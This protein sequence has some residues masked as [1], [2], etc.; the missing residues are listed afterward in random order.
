MCDVITVGAATYDIFLRSKDF[1]IMAA[2][3]YLTGRAECVPLGAKIEVRDITF[4]I[5]GGATNA[6]VSFARKGIKTGALARVGEDAA[7]REIIA[8][9]AKEGVSTRFIQETKAARTGHSII[10][11]TLTGERSMLVYRGAGRHLS[12]HFIPWA[13][14]A[15][16]WF[17]ISSLAGDL[18]LLKQVFEFAHQHKAKVAWNPG[19]RELHHDQK[20]LAHLLKHAEVIIL[21]QEE[22]ALLTGLPF[23]ETTKIFLTLKAHVPGMILMTR[24][25]AGALVSDGRHI[26]DAGTF[27]ER[28][29]V[30]RTG[31]GDAFGAGFVAGL[32]LDGS[33]KEALR[34]AAANATSVLEHVGAK[35]GLL[36]TRQLGEK[37]WAHLPVSRRVI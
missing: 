26:Y 10:M 2:G 9:L 20:A 19:E 13:D 25:P 35:A 17:Y 16:Q 33:V 1:S 11:V 3:Q 37:R 21:N 12:D 27:P 24:G 14:L 8:E 7:G 30:D 31:A 34:V 32:I 22:A 15:P 4:A 23:A 5:G 6:A 18:A 28:E 29:R 36:T